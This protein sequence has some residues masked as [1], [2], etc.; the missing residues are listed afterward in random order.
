ME[1]L[2]RKKIGFILSILFLFIVVLFSVMVYYSETKKINGKMDESIILGE[3]SISNSESD[4]KHAIE[5]FEHDYLNRTYAIDFM[6]S[7]AATLYNMEDLEKIQNLMEVESIHIIDE[8]GNIVLSS[9]KQ[10]IGI[11][12]REYKRTEDFVKLIDS[13]DPQANAI[14]LD[15][16][17]IAEKAERVYIAVKSSSPKYALVQIGVE[18]EVFDKFIQKYSLSKVVETI[19]TVWE[20]ALFIIDRNTG[21]IEGITENN[22]QEVKLDEAKNKEE[23]LSLLASAKEGKQIRINGSMKFLKTKIV[24]DKIIGVTINSKSIYQQILLNI[25]YLTAASGFLLLCIVWIY[26]KS[27]NRFVLKDIQHIAANIKSLLAGNRNVVFNTEFD[28]ELRSITTIMNEWKESYKRK[29]ERMSRIISTINSHI[30]TFECLYMINQSFFS[31]NMQSILD[32][33]DDTWNKISSSPKR[34]EEYLKSLMAKSQ[35]GIIPLGNNRFIHIVS[36]EK[37]NEFYGMIM[38]K[39]ADVKAKNEI[40]EELLIAQKAAEVDPLTKLKNRSGVERLVK[41]SL[42]EKPGEGTMIMFDL[43]NFKLVNDKRGHPEGDKLLKKF[44]RSLEAFSRPSDIIGRMGGDEFVVFIPT[45]IP[46]STVEKKLHSFL[47]R[48]REELR[49]YYED[50]NLSTSI[51]VAYVDASKNSYEDFYL[52]ADVGLY[53]AKEL[54]KDQF[55]INEENIRCMRKTCIQCTKDCEKRRLLGL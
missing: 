42:K 25:I 39:T 20:E 11:N 24:D 43:D 28:T 53:I 50:Y 18:R 8:K 22:E 37:D 6:L 30:A 16:V 4:T 23:Y 44:A 45:N 10:S 27:L 2:L 33:D 52:C 1:K 35:G 46:K 7:N 9:E 31:D 36:F 32:I 15:G 19:P 51:G 12:L 41:K 48:M 26:R 13:T 5:L 54:G 49:D 55:Y 29:G 40:Q 14:Q 17:S 47:E 21:E 34:F 3:T 38:D